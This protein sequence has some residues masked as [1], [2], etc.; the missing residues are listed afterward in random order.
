MG[1]ECRSDIDTYLST[2]GPATFLG[3]LKQRLMLA[4]N[5]TLDAGSAYNIPLIN[6]LIFY[7][8]IEARRDGPCLRNSLTHVRTLCNVS[9]A[10]HSEARCS[11]ALCRPHRASEQD[12]LQLDGER[13]IC[14]AARPQQMLA[15][16]PEDIIPR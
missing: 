11:H 1:R 3:G 2:R 8:G 9:D 10:G 6:A 4:E 12:L 7:C 15:Y 14:V 13:S 5:E 16:L